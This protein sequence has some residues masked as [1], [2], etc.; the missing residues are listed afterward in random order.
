MVHALMSFIAT[1]PNNGIASWVLYTVPV[2]NLLRRRAQEQQW[3]QAASTER[4]NLKSLNADREVF[5]KE[6]LVGMAIQ[7]MIALIA[8]GMF[9]SQP[10]LAPL[11]AFAIFSINAAVSLPYHFYAANFELKPMDS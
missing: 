2:V 4:S 1:T 10:R 8:A 7:T 5:Q 3:F 6:F 9:F 11:S